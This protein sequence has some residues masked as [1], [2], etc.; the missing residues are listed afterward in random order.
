MWDAAVQPCPAARFSDVQKVWG[1]GGHCPETES[2]EIAKAVN[3]SM[4]ILGLKF[5]KSDL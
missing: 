5:S 2:P 3:G 1:M 4:E